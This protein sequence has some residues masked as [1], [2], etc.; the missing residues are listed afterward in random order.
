METD[1]FWQRAGQLEGLLHR[2]AFQYTGNRFD[3]E[4]L[5]QE[6]LLA[7]FSRL[8]QLR[9]PRKL[10]RWLFVILRNRFLKR[11]RRTAPA[12]EQSYDDG[13]EYLDALG[14]LAAHEDAHQVLERKT[15]A[16]NVHRWLHA[17]PEPY[18][19]VLILYYLKEFSYQEIA[20]MLEIPLGTVMS[21]LSR[22]KRRL[23]TAIMKNALRDRA[24]GKLIPLARKG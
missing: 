11:V 24:R 9:D 16:E 18:Q 21:R 3:A 7:A 8:H 13:L 12:R 23:K 10:K 19:S 14:R 17:L 2:A 20:D 5:V 6:T 15:T 4:D 22:G 1:D